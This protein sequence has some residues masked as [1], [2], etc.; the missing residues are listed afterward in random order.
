MTRK[1][2]VILALMF[3][4][5]TTTVA[6][7]DILGDVLKVGGI[8]ILV[9]KFSKPLNDAVNTLTLNRGAENRD[10]TKVVPILS[11][12]KGGYIGMA[13]V[14]GPARR[15]ETVKAVAQL[16]GDFG[17]IGAKF[18]L[19][20]LVPIASENLKNIDRVRGIGVSA[21]IDIKL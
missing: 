13:Q 2:A 16:E 19:K 4:L 17:A 18:R 10:A 14:T 9:T 3:V 12:G 15:L 7:A 1:I 11:I 5:A 20:A 8:G 21:V 6:F